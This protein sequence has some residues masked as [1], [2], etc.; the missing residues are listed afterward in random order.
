MIDATLLRQIQ[1]STA[2][3]PF[4]QPDEPHAPAPVHPIVRLIAFYLPQ[5]HPIPENDAWWGK[6]FTEWTNVTKG[7]PRFVGHVQPR[8]PADLGFYDLR[9]PAVLHRQAALARRYGIG[10]FCFHHYWFNGRRLL[11][12][13]LQMLLS[14]PS[15]DMPFC[16]NWAN[17]NWTRRWDG[18]EN[19]ILLGQNHSAEDDVDF[20]RSLLPIVR[21]PRYITVKGRPL[22]MIYRPGLLPEPVA[23]MRR[24]RVVFTG[25]GLSNPY[26]VMAQGFG[27]HDPR[28]HGVDAAV[29]FPPHKVAPMPPINDS[30]ELLDPD[31]SGKVIDYEAV[32]QHAA[33]LPRPPYTLF[34]GVSPGWD[35]EARR[36]GRGLTFAHSTPATYATWLRAACQTAIAE[37]A[38][39][40]ERLVFINA[41][42]EWGEAAYLEPDRHFGYAYLQA[43]RQV[44]TDLIDDAAVE[45]QPREDDGSDGI[46][47]G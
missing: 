31:F 14:D 18:A 27:D 4:Y 25:A 10:G 45:S 3:G 7:L 19:E 11:E 41:W 39:A 44:L 8:L 13:P 42:N 24:W 46:E 43:T 12:K 16:I 1:A 30:L 40:D 20:A 29:E 35:N 6:G 23:T 38:T 32:A 26:I 37:A 36:A 15:L 22:I 47:D 2:P 5:F 28:Q 34:R 17:E 33:A 9:D 21:D